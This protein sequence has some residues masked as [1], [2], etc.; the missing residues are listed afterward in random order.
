MLPWGKTM[1][2]T[3]P[4]RRTMKLKFIYP[5]RPVIFHLHCS[6]CNIGVPQCDDYA[7]RAKRC[8]PIYRFFIGY[9]FDFHDI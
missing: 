3:T 4:A 1:F 5:P 9:Y 8:L 7:A 2:M 6:C